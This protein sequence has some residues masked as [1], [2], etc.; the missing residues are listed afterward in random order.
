MI[1]EKYVEVALVTA[2]LLTGLMRF[3]HFVDFLHNAT[4]L[5]VVGKSACVDILSE[6]AWLQT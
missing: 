4:N 6:A 1:Y 3:D 2:L 5:S